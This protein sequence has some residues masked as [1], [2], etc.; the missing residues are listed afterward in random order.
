MPKLRRTK[1]EMTNIRFSGLVRQY[2][3]ESG[4]RQEDLARSM[5]MEQ[6]S[7]SGRLLGKTSWKL[8]DM[9]RAAEELGFSFTIG[10][11]RCEV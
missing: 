11:D 6:Q 10:E 9:V 4:K 2:L 3:A 5:G 8:E 1:E 7:L